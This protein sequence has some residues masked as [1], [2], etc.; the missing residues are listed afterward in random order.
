MSDVPSYTIITGDQATYELA[1]AIR[2][3]DEHMFG[4]MILLLGGFYQAHNY[5]MA[6]FKIMRGCGA[7][8]ILVNAGLCLEGTVKKIFGEK[9][10]ASLCMR[11]GS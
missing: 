4:N 10:T 11:C 2:N 9:A 7:E 1:L 6:I 8:E 5:M 3:K